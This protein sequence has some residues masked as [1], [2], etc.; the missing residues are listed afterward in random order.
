MPAGV[1]ACRLIELPKTTPDADAEPNF[2]DAPLM[3][4]VPEMVTA[5]PPAAGPSVGLI[6]VIEGGG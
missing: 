4:P 1:V 5:V 6:P 3:N 2:I